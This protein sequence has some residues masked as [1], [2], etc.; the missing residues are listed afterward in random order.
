MANRLHIFGVPLVGVILPFI[1]RR[2]IP[3]NRDGSIVNT[4]EDDLT[5]HAYP[6]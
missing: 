5:D 4:G 6:V 3:I 1:G 2:C